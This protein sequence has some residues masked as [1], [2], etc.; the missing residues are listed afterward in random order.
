MRV[1]IA[2]AVLIG[3]TL[4]AVGLL[5]I[6]LYPF[7]SALLFA[8]VLATTFHPWTTR[9]AARLGD[10]RAA[11]AALMTAATAVIIVI[12][13]SILVV[14][15]GGQC[16]E[17]I[18][19]VRETVDRGGLPALI[20]DLPPALRDFA[21]DVMR[22]LPGGPQQVNELADEQTGRAAAAVGG[23]ILATSQ[24][25]L[26]VS[27]MLVGF[28]FLL[29]DGSRLVAWIVEVAPIGRART[30]ELLSEFRKVSEA[31]LFS[32][33]ATA[34]VQAL[35]ALVGFLIAGVPQPLFFTLVTFIT[36]FVPILGAAVVSVACA[37][38]LLLT[39]HPGPALFLA[40]WAVVVVGLVD[41]LV[42]P[43]LLKGRMEVHG[44]VI[45]FAL[46]GGLAAFGPAGFIAGPLVVSFFLAV[47]RMC[48]RDLRN[49]EVEEK[50]LETEPARGGAR[51]GSGRAHP[52]RL[53]A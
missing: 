26:H 38:W 13:V 24:F 36:A 35:A 50:R 20:R 31:I 29:L 43:L 18:A 39:G 5:A 21:G 14:V 1:R 45:F 49:A 19:Y 33:L 30:R 2:R 15:L 4:L 52:A 47:V 7:A 27:L 40:V 41:N 46:L 12:P 51:A 11:A 23:A 17:A 44:A 48:Q 28:Y 25:V 42:K 6:V 22:T 53:T 8:A 10:R 9:L 3:L 34:G 32:S 37:G 16:V